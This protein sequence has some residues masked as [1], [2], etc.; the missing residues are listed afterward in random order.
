M[1]GVGEKGMEG[2]ADLQTGGGA[3]GWESRAWLILLFI[4][5]LPQ[6]FS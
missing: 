5:P 1:D 2:V 3:G 6:D 4:T